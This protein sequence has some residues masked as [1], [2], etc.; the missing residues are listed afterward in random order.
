MVLFSKVYSVKHVDPDRHSTGII[1]IPWIT[2]VQGDPFGER[3]ELSAVGCSWNLDYV[4]I[5]FWFFH[6]IFWYA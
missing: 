4:R 2:N 6:V 1:S 5:Y 3:T